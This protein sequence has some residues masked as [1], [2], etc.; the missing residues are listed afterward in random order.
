MKLSR[1]ETKFEK[2][3]GATCL[4]LEHEHQGKCYLRIDCRSIETA[5]RFK[6][7]DAHDS[8]NRRQPFL[9]NGLARLVAQT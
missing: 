8:T 3:E 6:R 2:D 5:R 1:Q 4:E 7:D 9:L